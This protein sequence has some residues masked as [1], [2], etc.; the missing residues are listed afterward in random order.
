[1][2]VP[3][4]TVSETNSVTQWH[5]HDAAMHIATAMPDKKWRELPYIYTKTS[6]L[7]WPTTEQRY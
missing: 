6:L 5:A 3:N 1:M 2:I 4:D 7:P